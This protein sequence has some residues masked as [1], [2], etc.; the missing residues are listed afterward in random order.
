MKPIR[1]YKVHAT[2]RT[3]SNHPGKIT[4][5]VVADSEEQAIERIKELLR[6][7][8]RYSAVNNLNVSIV[9]N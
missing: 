6:A 1:I 5:H 9:E 7:D 4:R 2:W 3:K 8:Q